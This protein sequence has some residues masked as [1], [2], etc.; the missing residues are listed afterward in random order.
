MSDMG[1]SD[2]D[3][4]ADWAESDVP[5]ADDSSQTVTGAEAEEIG[6][7]FLRGRPNARSA[8]HLVTDRN[9]RS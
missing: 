6:R 7:Q 4:M 5:L 1:E 9:R 2:W 8:H 3:R